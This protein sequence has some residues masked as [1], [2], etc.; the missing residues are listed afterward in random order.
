MPGLTGWSQADFYQFNPVPNQDQYTYMNWVQTNKDFEFIKTPRTILCRNEAGRGAN[1]RVPKEDWSNVS[2]YVDNTLICW[3]SCDIDSEVNVV[4]LD[5]LSLLP[6]SSNKGN[7][8]QHNYPNCGS[9]GLLNSFFAFPSTTAG[10]ESMGQFILNTVPVGDYVVIETWGTGHLNSWQSVPNLWNAINPPKTSIL[11]SPSLPP[12]NMPYILV[13]QKGHSLFSEKYNNTD[14]ATFSLSLSIPTNYTS[15]SAQSTLIGPGKNWGQ[16]HFNTVP[17]ASD[18]TL[19]DHNSFQITSIDNSLQPTTNPKLILTSP[20]NVTDYMSNYY[21]KLNYNTLD[22]NYKT[23]GQLKSWQVYFDNYA[24]GAVVKDAKYS[25]HADTLQEGDVMKFVVSFK[26]ISPNLKMDSILAVCIVKNSSNVVVQTT[27]KRLPPIAYNQWVTD[28]VSFTTTGYTG[29]NTVTMEFNCINPKTGAYD[30]LE[31]YH[32]NNV[33]QKY[34]F[35]QKDKRNPLFNV[36]F[37]GVHIMNGDIVSAKPEI[38]ISLKDENKYFAIDD[39]SLVSVYLESMTLGVEKQLYFSGSNNIAQMSFQ[40]GALHFAPGTLTNNVAKVSFNPIFGG[41]DGLYQ[42]RVKGHDKAGNESG[43]F[44]YTIQFDVILES[45]ITNLI[46]YPNPFTTATKFV[47]TLTGSEIPTDLRIQIFTITGKLVKEIGL[48][49]LG[50]IHIG[51]NITQYAWNGTDK[52]GEKLANGVYLYR[53]FSSINGN[54][55]EHRNAQLDQYY[56]KGFGKMYLMR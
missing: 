54:K 33:A 14:I 35:V 32:F 7:Y 47:F 11:A 24:D 15:G 44:D 31:Q 49:E 23:P 37:D 12:D 17:V 42:L 10:L 3:A 9:S 39:T 22:T 34:F 1:M 2:V 45:S 21:M 4:V 48:D 28:S 6:W 46:N 51:Q 36:T 27:Y 52:Y 20:V 26:N 40:C 25:F 53:V 29:L 19:A 41:R 13:I 50:P 16:L 18:K 56:K 38:L 43:A 55:I 30:Q 8:G 5:S